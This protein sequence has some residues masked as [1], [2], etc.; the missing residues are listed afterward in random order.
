MYFAYVVACVVSFTR[1]GARVDEKDAKGRTPLTL[2]VELR[3]S[4]VVI[5]QVQSEI[6]SLLL[7]RMLCLS[8]R[9]DFAACSSRLRFNRSD[10]ANPNETL[11]WIS[12]TQRK[13]TGTP[14]LYYLSQVRRFLSFPSCY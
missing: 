3:T 12:P 14:L 8:S 5:D 9:I 13:W 10:G 6:I 11:S 7:S 4:D 2:C 1:S